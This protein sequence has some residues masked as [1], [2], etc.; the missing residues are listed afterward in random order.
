MAETPKSPEPASRPGTFRWPPR[1]VA[2]A[3]VLYALW[4]VSCHATVKRQGSGSDLFSLFGIALVMLA[5]AAAGIARLRGARS[6]GDTLDRCVAEPLPVPAGPVASP[7]ARA[8]ATAGALLVLGLWL[9]LEDAWWVWI[10]AT[11]CVVAGTAW[12]LVRSRSE[13]WEVPAPVEGRAWHGPVLLALCAASAYLAMCVGRSN[14][15]DAYYVNIAVALSDQP[16]LPLYLRDTIHDAGVIMMAPYRVHTYELLAGALSHFSGVPALWVMHV[17]LVAVTGALLPLVWAMLLRELDPQRWLAMLA[18]VLGWFLLDGDDYFTPSMHAYG[19]LFQGKAVMYSVAVPVAVT[20]GLRFGRA[21]SAS[22][23]AALCLIQVVMVGLSSTGLWLAPCVAATAVAATMR[24]QRAFAAAA[25]M[26]LLASFYPVCAG[27]WVRAQMSAGKP[28][29]RKLIAGSLPDAADTTFE[30]L[31]NAFYVALSGW[32]QTFLYFGV[33]LLSWGLARTHMMQRYLLAFLVVF[34]LLFANP[35]LTDILSRSVVGAST[36]KRIV[37]F[38]PL[39]AGLACFFTMLWSARQAPRVRTAA[40]AIS[41]GLF[42][43]FF[44]LAPEMTIFRHALVRATPALKV[45]PHGYEAAQ[46]LTQAVPERSHVLA[47]VHVA[48]FL[49]L[50]QR[51]PYPLMVKPKWFP[52]GTDG[53]RRFRLRRVVD[54]RGKA[55]AGK[56]RRWFRLELEHYRVQGLVLTKQAMGSERMAEGLQKIGFVQR[57]TLP[58]FQIWTRAT[59]GGPG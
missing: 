38:L 25:V 48:M 19:R 2:L 23:F 20:Y 54:R 39:G 55:M 57:H 7:L 47:T 8:L 10:A 44:S 49:P 50:V 42:G 58:R 6:I 28:T 45:S 32:P 18:V 26:G 31:L 17:G 4:T 41:V 52:K 29:T 14:T 24:L 35:F 11:A 34:V 59:E 30:P 1:I 12:V 56:H 13:R 36:L 51:H 22:R 43:A 3:V 37:W 15:D 5:L 16:E 21:P 40:V 9:V 46:L 27:L 53:P 33:L